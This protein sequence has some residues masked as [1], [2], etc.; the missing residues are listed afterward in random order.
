[1]VIPNIRTG[2]RPRPGQLQARTN[3]NPNPNPDPV[4][5]PGRGRTAQTKD[6]TRYLRQGHKM[7]VVY[8]RWRDVP[9]CMSSV[10]HRTTTTTTT[11]LISV[12][13]SDD[14]AARR[15]EPAPLLLF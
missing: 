11:T 6:E 15:C 5:G 4:L 1:M 8:I 10:K 13:T 12:L 9:R 3:P 7:A 14:E 2:P